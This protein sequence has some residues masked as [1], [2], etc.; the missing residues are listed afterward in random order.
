MQASASLRLEQVS[1]SRSGRELFSALD[2]QLKPGE[3]TLIQGDTGCGKSSLLQ[4]MAGLI[5][6]TAGQ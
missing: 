6:P 1:L 2:L 5:R 4:L 3:L